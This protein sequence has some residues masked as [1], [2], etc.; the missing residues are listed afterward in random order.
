IVAVPSDNFNFRQGEYMKRTIMV[1]L[2]IAA[3]GVAGMWIGKRN[4]PRVAIEPPATESA[5]ATATEDTGPLNHPVATTRKS[6]ATA[7][8]ATEP[9]VSPQISP[10]VVAATEPV[11]DE[12][13]QLRQAVDQLVSRETSFQQK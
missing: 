8:P 11:S 13:T 2:C 4:H 9:P 3:A 12:T 7:N 10:A 1:G 5:P 6:G